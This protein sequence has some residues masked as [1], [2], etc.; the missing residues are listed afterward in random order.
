MQSMPR[1]CL[2]AALLLSMFGPT[3]TRRPM[4]FLLSVAG[5]GA[6]EV[7]LEEKSAFVPFTYHD[8]LSHICRRIP[9]DTRRYTIGWIV[10]YL[11][12]TWGC[13]TRCR[14]PR[15]IE[16]CRPGSTARH[17]YQFPS[18]SGSTRAET[19]DS[20]VHLKVITASQVLERVGDCGR[21][22]QS[23]FWQGR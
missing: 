18:N 13:H 3:A 21:N 10:S 5:V 6:W 2:Y 22:L 4:A 8:Q 9:T 20:I 7:L 12:S 17:H 16:R 11:G 14:R 15:R 19:T 23:E 1:K